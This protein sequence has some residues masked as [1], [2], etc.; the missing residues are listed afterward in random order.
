MQTA[1]QPI[2]DVAPSDQDSAVILSQERPKDP[3]F[4]TIDGFIA[5]P[6]TCPLTEGMT[7]ARVILAASGPTRGAGD[8]VA[9]ARGGGASAAGAGGPRR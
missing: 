8:V 5:R 4:V 6:G 1:G 7:L 9:P 3:G 2:R